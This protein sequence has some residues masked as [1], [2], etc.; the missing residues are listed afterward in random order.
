M[1]LK[2]EPFESSPRWHG[3]GE[4]RTQDLGVVLRDMMVPACKL[5][6]GY[7]ASVLVFYVFVYVMVM[8]F[9]A[10]SYEASAASLPGYL[11][12]ISKHEYLPSR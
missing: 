10:W 4:D 5:A 3:A 8:V 11:P 6:G 2:V 7:C 1:R 9:V 12:I